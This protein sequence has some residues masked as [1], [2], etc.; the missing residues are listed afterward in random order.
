MYLLTNSSLTNIKTKNLLPIFSW[1]PV[2]LWYSHDD[3]L[4]AA[5]TLYTWLSLIFCM[6]YFILIRDWEIK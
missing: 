4:K 2:Y 5:E 6:T 1:R 3:A